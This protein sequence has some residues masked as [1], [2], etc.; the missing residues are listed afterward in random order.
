MINFG[1]LPPRGLAGPFVVD[2]ESKI[3]GEVNNE[4]LVIFDRLRICE[5]LEGVDLTVYPEWDEM[6]A[7]N[8]EQ[9]PAIL[10]TL[11]KA[12]VATKG[13]AKKVGTTAPKSVFRKR[14]RRDRGGH[15]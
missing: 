3:F 5:H 2:P 4:A 10:T 14:V 13:H 12:A 1:P 11:S 8:A 9:R 7:W 15:G 6:A